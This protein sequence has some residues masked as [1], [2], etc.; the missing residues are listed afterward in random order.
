MSASP[1]LLVVKT[2]SLGDVIHM[3]PALSD[4]AQA[5]PQLQ[6]DWLV[7]APL[8]AIPAWHPAVRQVIPLAMRRWKRQWT[9]AAAWREVAAVRARL[10]DLPCDVVVD[11]QG[12]VKSALWV[13]M[14]SGTRCGY[15]RASAREP[16]A[17]LFYDRHF[18]VP[19]A[20]HAIE[21]NRR[22]LAQALGYRVPPGAP[23]YGLRGLGERL[24]A[25]P[26]VAAALPLL[27]ARYGVGLHGTSRADKEW[28]Q[29]H[30][31][32]L[33]QALA[34][35]G[36]PLVLPWGNDREQQRA[37][38]IAQAAPGTQV[39][40]ALGLDAMACVL[41]RSTVVVGVDTGLMH[42]AAALGK[43]GL[44]LYTATRPALTGAISDRHAPAA[45]RNREAP[46]DLRADAVTAETLRLLSP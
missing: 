19:R 13:R 27:P 40:P 14:A 31:V 37:Q 22:L 12:L 10:R 7:E 24:R 32:A 39:L 6:A 38:Q 43:P 30:W 25:Q 33:A 11:A 29:A 18:G 16:L 26:A 20:L 17:A 42:L 34:S 28:P 9:Q 41:D 1:R 23:D 15:D 2:S 36:C 5:L 44:A 3:L 35:A 4:A 21:R 45:L 46:D 8:A